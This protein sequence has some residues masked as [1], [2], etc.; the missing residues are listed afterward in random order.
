L[1]LE[2]DFAAGEAR[3][4]LDDNPEPVRLALDVEAWRGGRQ[5]SER[6]RRLA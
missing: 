2:I 6:E 5:P 4:S 1:R 3:L